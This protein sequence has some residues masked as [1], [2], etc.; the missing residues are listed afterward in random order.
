[1]KGWKINPS[2]DLPTGF[3]LREDSEKVY[4]YRREELVASFI[5]TAATPEAILAAAR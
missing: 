4:L 5:S 3:S 2:F 1:M